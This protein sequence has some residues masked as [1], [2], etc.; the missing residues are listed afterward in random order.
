MYFFVL[1][2]T[3]INP[4]LET[5]GR[6]Y[7][8]T[9]KSEQRVGK[10]QTIK[11]LKFMKTKIL[12]IAVAIVCSSLGVASAQKEQK[13]YNYSLSASSNDKKIYVSPVL[14]S[15]TNSIIESDGYLNPSIQSLD[16][17]WHKKL[18]FLGL[19]QGVSYSSYNTRDWWHDYDHVYDSRQDEI[20]RYKKNG[21]EI[22]YIDDF[23]YRKEK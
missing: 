2:Q 1:K 14:T 18:E 6:E 13:V 16:R 4:S 22:T 7:G 23:Y 11:N 3:T 9:R 12:F 15:T 8:I 10:K 21:Y 17:Q 20:S 19:A 5:R